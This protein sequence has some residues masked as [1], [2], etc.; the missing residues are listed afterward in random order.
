MHATAILYRVFVASWL[1]GYDGVDD[2]DRS[3]LKHAAGV[4]ER[5]LIQICIKMT[6]ALETAITT[7]HKKKV[8]RRLK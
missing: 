7:R 1:Q 5:A 3:E 8:L 4:P 2:V 6:S